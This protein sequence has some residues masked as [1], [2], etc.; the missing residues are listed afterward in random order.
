M[1]IQSII[2]YP[3]DMVYEDFD[4]RL[5]VIMLAVV[6][7]PDFK[8]ATSK[9]D[10]IENGPEYIIPQ[11]FPQTLFG[12]E[13]H[14]AVSDAESEIASLKAEGITLATYASPEYP[15]QLRSIHDLPPLV[16]I[17]GQ[18]HHTDPLA[19]AI[20]GSRNV[21]NW[22]SEFASTLATELAAQGTPVIS[23]LALGI[24]TA[25]MTASL[26]AN[27]RTIG[28]IGT[29]FNKS[30]P[31]ENA[32]LQQEIATNHLL[33]SQFHPAAPGSR[34]S[35][36]M[37]NIVMSGLSSLTFIVEAGEHSGTRTQANAAVRHARPVIITRA[38]YE[39]TQWGKELVS[40]YYRS[41]YVVQSV[42]EALQAIRAAQQLGRQSVPSVKGS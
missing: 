25:A 13:Y 27:N 6:R 29:G 24:D 16:Y 3:R 30:Y 17:K 5:N 34:Q 11:L 38:V 22:G 37:R 4:E 39:N 32:S 23:G 28:V 21:S 35:F 26:K 20:V 15:P 12:D 14:Q 7:H 8:W 36:P 10:I 18:Q 2:E 42:D 40:N 41:L 9:Y 19:V 1:T 33:I 31:R